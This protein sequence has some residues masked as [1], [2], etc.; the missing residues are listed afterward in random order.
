MQGGARPQCVVGG[1]R[2]AADVRRDRRR[3]A[4]R[5]RT[6]ATAPGCDEDPPE[7]QEHQDTQEPSELDERADPP[8]SP[9]GSTGQAEEQ[10]ESDAALLVEALGV[11]WSQARTALA[12]FPGQ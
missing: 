4:P 10:R 7:T 6:S 5:S 11:D 9:S 3:S 1:V 2:L 8:A 12:M